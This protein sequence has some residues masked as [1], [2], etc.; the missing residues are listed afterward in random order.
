MKIVFWN[1]KGGVGKTALAYNVARDL[2]YFLLSNDKSIIE[3]AY[4]EKA[5]I[6]RSLSEI[7]SCRRS[8]R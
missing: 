8:C 2:N 1:K 5:K 4:P 7:C 6:D 3:K